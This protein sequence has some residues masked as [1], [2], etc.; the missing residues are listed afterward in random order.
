MQGAAR[1][2]DICTGHD[3]CPPRPLITGS[4]DVFIND[5]GA[6]R[7]GLDKFALHG[8]EDHSPHSAVVISGSPD[9]FVNDCPLGRILDIVSCGGVV[10]TGSKDVLIN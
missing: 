10:T 4:A 5:L 2:T 1:I 3:S 8:C 7:V 9:V 6:N